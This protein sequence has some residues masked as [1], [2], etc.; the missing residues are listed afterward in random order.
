MERQYRPRK[1]VVEE[2]SQE[3]SL[4]HKVNGWECGWIACLEVTES[5]GAVERDRYLCHWLS[6]L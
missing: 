5:I 2:S 1:S 3:N 4:G 6:K